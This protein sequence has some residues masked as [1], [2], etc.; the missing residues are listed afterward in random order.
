[1]YLV[2]RGGT[3]WYVVVRDERGE[4]SGTRWKVWPKRSI[5][6]WCFA[7][8]TKKMVHFSKNEA[9]TNREGWKFSSKNKRGGSNKGVEG[10][11]IFQNK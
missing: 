3:Q 6:A 4:R 7:I 5:L 8:Y 10:G 11:K 2:V 1:M 9:L